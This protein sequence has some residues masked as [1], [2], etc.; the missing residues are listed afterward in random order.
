MMGRGCMLCGRVRPNERFGGRGL[1]SRICG[2]CRRMPKLERQK[3]LRMSELQGFLEQSNI[4]KKNIK[5]LY[6]A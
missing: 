1:R 5:R 6:L 3:A 4:S 2:H